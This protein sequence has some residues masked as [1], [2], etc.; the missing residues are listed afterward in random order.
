MI[1]FLR[2]NLLEADAEAL[3]NTVNTVGVMGKGVALQFSRA[4]PE[5]LKPY[6]RACKNG[7]LRLGRVLATPTASLGR[8]PQ[9]IIQ[10]PTKGH[11]KEVSNLENIRTGLQSLINELKRLELRSVALPPLGCG[12]GGLRWGDVRPLIEEAF[13][14][15]PNIAVSVFEPDEQPTYHPIAAGSKPDLTPAKAILL[16]LFAAYHFPGE[17]FGRTEANKL[18]YF[19]QTVGVKDLQLKFVKQTFGP[20]ADNL[21]HQLRDMEGHY[22]TGVGDLTTASEIQVVPSALQEVNRYLESRSDAK[23]ALEQVNELV[24]GFDDPY[25]MELLSTV[26]WLVTQENALTLEDVCQGIQNWNV[27]KRHLFQNRQHIQIAFD[28][29]EALDWFRHEQPIVTPGKTKTAY[30]RKK[31]RKVDA[32]IRSLEGGK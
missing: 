12:Q 7:D 29:L 8:N 26:H 6:Q 25:G 19:V 20:Y 27:R 1:T 23:R 16:K 21:K 24:F 18:A 2:G 28:H 31:S 11:W 13:R 17:P 5:I 14:A 9:F 30:Q 10:F 4:F 22:I 3:V 32:F 15:L